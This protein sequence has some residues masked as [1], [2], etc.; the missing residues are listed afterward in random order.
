MRERNNPKNHIGGGVQM[1]HREDFINAMGM[2][3]KSFT[4]AVDVAL[5]QVKEMEARI[6]T[7]E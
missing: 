4:S 5:Q 1:I 3:D 2:P 6:V 7:N